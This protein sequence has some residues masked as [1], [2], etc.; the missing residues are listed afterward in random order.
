[1]A[2]DP[3]LKALLRYL[4]TETVTDEA[5]TLADKVA[6]FKRHFL[7]AASNTASPAV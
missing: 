4:S 7:S 1:M 3:K 2:D 5:R 6:A